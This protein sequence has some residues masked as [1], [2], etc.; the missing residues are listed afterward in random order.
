M[1]VNDFNQYFYSGKYGF[2]FVQTFDE[3]YYRFN[4]KCQDE[5]M[6][7][8]NIIHDENNSIVNSWKVTQKLC[9][10]VCDSQAMK[11]FQ[12]VLMFQSISQ[13]IHIF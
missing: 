7:A 9:H 1:S 5:G 3:T 10:W 12:N 4:S 8:L 13:G 2:L 11:E 6:P